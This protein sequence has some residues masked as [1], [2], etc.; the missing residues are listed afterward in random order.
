MFSTRS[1][2]DLLGRLK[3]HGLIR[4]VVAQRPASICAARILSSILHKELIRFEVSFEQKEEDAGLHIFIDAEGE[5]GLH[6]NEVEDDMYRCTC[7]SGGLGCCMLAFSLAR[8]MNY[9]NYEILWPIIVCFEF[10]SGGREALCEGCRRL[11]ADLV[12]EVEKESSAAEV[13]GIFYER[14]PSIQFLNSTSLFLALRND[15]GFVLENRLFHR[16]H[17]ERKIYEHLARKGISQR[18]SREKYRNLSHQ[19]KEL[20]MHSFRQDRVFLKR[21]GHDTEV[22][23]MENFFLI[24]FHLLRGDCLGAF[25]CLSDKHVGELEDSVV[26][27]HRFTDVFKDAVANTRRSNDILFFKVRDTLGV[28]SIA[29]LLELLSVHFGLY[30]RS[31]HG[32]RYR[33]VI[34]VEGHP[35]ERLAVYSDSPEIKLMLDEMGSAVD[36]CTMVGRAEFYSSIGRL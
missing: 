34:V 2:R 5:N 33:K 12:V 13:D 1:P 29:L 26:F 10:H 11:H 19:T 18:S 16:R 17:E 20:I 14:R 31:R 32:G 8:S 21:I 23:P 9:I 28:K 27:Y 35:E 25:L 15:P 3:A 4:V 30:I 36:G 6:L 22:S 24:C 7:P